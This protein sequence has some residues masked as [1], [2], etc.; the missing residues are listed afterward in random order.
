MDFRPSDE[1]VEVKNL[2]FIISLLAAGQVSAGTLAPGLEAMM[3][4]MDDQDVIRVLVV[5]VARSMS[6]SVRMRR[7]LKCPDRNW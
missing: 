4:N 7:G 5:P 3:S 6:I 1:E 2:I